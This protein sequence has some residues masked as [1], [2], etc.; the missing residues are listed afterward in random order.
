MIF[1][2]VYFWFRAVCGGGSP[3]ACRA[4]DPRGPS[5]FQGLL[6]FAFFAYMYFIFNGL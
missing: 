6:F 3:V 2:S 4:A 5:W 1:K